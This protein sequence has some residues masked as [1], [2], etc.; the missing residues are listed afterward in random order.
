MCHTIS[1]RWLADNCPAISAAIDTS[2]LIG[3]TAPGL[4]A[5]MVQASAQSRSLIGHGT[6]T[7]VMVV[8]IPG[9]IAPSLEAQHR[10]DNGAYINA[11]DTQSVIPTLEIQ[12]TG[13]AA[14]ANNETG[15][16]DIKSY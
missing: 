8:C 5:T 4:S 13:A 3:I 16:Y 1:A 6:S 11:A 15:F 2:V 7:M 14:D 12:S 9:C 10:H